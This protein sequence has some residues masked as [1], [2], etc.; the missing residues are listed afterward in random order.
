MEAAGAHTPMKKLGISVRVR[1]AISAAAEPPALPLRHSPSILP[2][3]SSR[4]VHKPL[5]IDNLRGEVR[6]FASPVRPLL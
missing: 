6:I 2:S 4:P 3:L 1:D 5:F